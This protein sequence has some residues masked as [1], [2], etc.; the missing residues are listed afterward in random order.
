[1][2]TILW[3]SPLQAPASTQPPEDY[4]YDADP[5]VSVQVQL[6]VA[7]HATCRTRRRLLQ[8]VML[9]RCKIG[10]LGELVLGVVV[11]PVLA[12]LVGTDPGVVLLASVRA[13]MLGGGG[14]AAADVTTL[15]APAQVEPPPG[16]GLTFCATRATGQHARVDSRHNAHRQHLQ[17]DRLTKLS[18]TSI[19]CVNRSGVGEKICTL[20]DSD[21]KGVPTHNAPLP[22][23]QAAARQEWGRLTP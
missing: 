13:R 17:R 14:V 5:A 20:S 2:P 9:R 11:E 6:P 4:D 15:R 22:V 3:P 16:A 7:G 18:T 1:L 8:R 12:G 19:R 10:P 21:G 23:D